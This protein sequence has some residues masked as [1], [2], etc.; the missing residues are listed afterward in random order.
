MSKSPINPN[1]ALAGGI[2]V[3][4]L[5]L[6]RVLGIFREMVIAWKFGQSPYT[7][8]YVLSF[9]IPDLLFFMIAG[10]ALSSAFIPIFSEYLHTGKEK[11]AWHIY[12][13][14]VTFMSIVVMVFIVLAWI[15][16]YPL[17]RLIA[18]GEP[19][20]SYPLIVEMSRIVLPAQFAFF[21]GGIM[22]GTLYARQVFAVP[23]LGP[24]IY[25]IGIIF[26]GLFLAGFFLEGVQGLSWGAL[27]GA[28]IGNLLIPLLVMRRM[29]SE[30]RFVIDLKHPGV[31]KVFKLMAPVVLGLSLPGVFAL[32][33][34]AFSTYYAD[35][36]NTAMNVANRLMQAP[37]G[38][39]GQALALAAFPALAQFFAQGKMDMFRNQLAKTVRTVLVLT[40][41]V[42]VL[43]VVMPNELVRVAFE[44]RSFRIEDTARTA[45]ILRM[46]GIGIAAWS[47]SPVLMRGF[48][49]VQ[50]SITPIVIGTLTTALFVAMSL[51]VVQT[52]RPYEMLALAG[53]ISAI[54]MAIVM[55]LA[56]RRV[57][58]GLDLVGILNTAARSL[59]ASLVAAVV[60]LLIVY[61]APDVLSSAGKLGLLFVVG[62]GTIVF[63]WVYYWV[64]KRIGLDEVGYVERALERRR[65]AKEQGLADGSG[66]S[67]AGADSGDD[68]GSEPGADVPE[69]GSEEDSGQD[70]DPNQD[71]DR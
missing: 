68:T 12:S 24:N 60:P 36:V 6:S 48:F 1:F 35:G 8:A 3:I 16:A 55:L 22:F 46:F 39:F 23:G 7:D 33:L 42:S 25:N 61:V 17:A 52:G 26:G 41:P 59:V 70:Q 62:V 19:E 49:A 14:V 2:M 54:V 9:Q 57:T 21:I 27:I 71:K 37:L 30:Y 40:I 10:G 32:I 11:E 43:F 44:Y 65:L 5:F 13:S 56:V 51:W 63:G 47:L 67:D 53:S 66:S 45:S 58:D 69:D 18:P 38:V 64:A 15:Y 31:R 29:Q 34:Q 4:S 20:S 50:R 28:F